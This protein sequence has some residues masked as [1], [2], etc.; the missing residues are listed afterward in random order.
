M[1]TLNIYK[2]HFTAPLHIGDRRDDYGVSLRSIASDTLYAALTSCLA[3]MER[4]IPA[5]GDLGFAIS[6][7]FPFF[8]EKKDSEP[9][10]FFPKPL[11]QRS[12]NVDATKLKTIK[13]VAWI[14]SEYFSKTLK[15]DDLFG[16]GD[17][18]DAINGI[19]LSCSKID[20]D[21]VYSQVTQRVTIDRS[22]KE[23]AMPFYMDNIFFK[24]E[25]GLF[26]IADGDTENLNIALN[27]LAEEGLGTD[28][29]VGNGCFTYEKDSIELQLPESANHG[30]SLSIFFPES[31]EQL[32]G[33][34]DNDSIAYDFERRGGWITT[35]P[36]NTI[37]KNA[38]HGFTPGSVFAMQINGL[39]HKGR[40]V[41]LKPELEFNAKIN[42]PIW[43][44]GKAL[45]LPLNVE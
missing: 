9:V 26:F 39:T 27:L 29:N 1:A 3:M 16:N 10:Y 37:R 22:G 23:D 11:L 38:I 6:S 45:F 7:L 12:L 31:K 36:N 40:I 14:D 24:G 44:C 8:Q 30:V 19:Y 15:G 28:R 20:K 42:H 17:A 13:K 43:R 41:D 34:L 2:L 25:S 5:D 4:K 18:V 35:C 32:V 33:M 21:F